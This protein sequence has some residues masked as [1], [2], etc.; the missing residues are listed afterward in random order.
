MQSKDRMFGRDISNLHRNTSQLV[1]LFLTSQRAEQIKVKPERKSV[2]YSKPK[3]N[4]VTCHE[5]KLK[6][7]Y[8]KARKELEE[9]LSGADRKD[10]DKYGYC[11]EYA[12][13]ITSYLCNRQKTT[14]A[15][16]GYMI[17]QT[18]INENIRETLVDWMTSTS[19]RLNLRRETLFM[20]VN[21]LDRYLDTEKLT[22]SK[23]QLAGVTALVLSAKYEEIYPPETKEF[24]VLSKR[25]MMKE[26]V[27]RMES[28][29]L[30]RLNFELSGTSVLPFLG[31]FLKL[32]EASEYINNLALY[33]SELQLMNYS[34]LK[35][36]P[37]TIAAACSYLA[38]IA[39][40][41]KPPI[42]DSYIQA[43]SQCQEEDVRR[44]GREMLEGFKEAIKNELFAAKRRFSQRNFM[45]VGRLE[46]PLM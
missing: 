21:L 11:A 3:V 30:R 31:R 5:A 35:Y 6:D 34:M 46:F 28:Q 2:I 15:H 26:E 9:K 19:E 24:I 42:W 27:F 20:A 12:E 4:S 14:A 37:A 40:K 1:F 45:E 32:I 43:Q 18:D 16:H 23:L 39:V 10:I 8:F 25:P 13:G 17:N 38:Y 29:I 36:L 22:K 33:Y 44:C 41:G 7:F